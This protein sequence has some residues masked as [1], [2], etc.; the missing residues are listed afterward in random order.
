MQNAVPSSR[1]AWDLFV[2]NP[3]DLLVCRRKSAVFNDVITATSVGLIS[4]VI[5]TLNE[6]AYLEQTLAPLVSLSE[7]VIEIIVVD[8]GSTNG[9]NHSGSRV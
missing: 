1:Q 7:H 5:P 4:I 2:D 8:S 3:E 6:S 9:V